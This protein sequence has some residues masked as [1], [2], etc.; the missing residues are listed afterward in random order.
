MIHQVIQCRLAQ[1]YYILLLCQSCILVYFTDERKHLYNFRLI[2]IHTVVY[3]Y[4]CVVCVHSSIYSTYYTGY[5]SF[6]KK[7]KE[8]LI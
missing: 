4:T 3:V 6:P 1:K 5:C 8:L 7:Q 2:T